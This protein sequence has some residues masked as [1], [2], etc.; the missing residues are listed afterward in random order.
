MVGL[1]T[2]PVI[3]YIEENPTYLAIVDPFF[4][5]IAHGEL[6]VVTSVLTLLEVLVQPIRRRNPQLVQKYRDLLLGS[7]GLS[8]VE[9]SRNIAEEA[10]QLRAVHNMSTPDSVQMATAIVRKAPVFLTNDKNLRSL[11]T[12]QVLV[13][14]DMKGNP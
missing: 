11:P 4:D 12:L 7:K 10:A 14:D 9:L 1:D 3:Y 2:T 5:A 8:I 13:L 6:T